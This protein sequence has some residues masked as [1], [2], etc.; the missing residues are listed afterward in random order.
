MSIFAPI[1]GYLTEVSTFEG[2]Y[3]YARE[4][5]GVILSENNIIELSIREENF[6]GIRLGLPV[7]VHLLGLRG[8]PL[9]GEV[10]AV[11]YASSSASKRRTVNV[12]LSVNDKTKR[13]ITP[14]MTGEAS[15]TKNIREKTLLIPRRAVFGDLVYTVKQNRIKAQPIKI[16]FRGLHQV[17]VSSGLRKGDLVVVEDLAMLRNDDKAHIVRIIEF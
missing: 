12:E 3:V 10:S 14:G 15:I 5:L 13:M 17:E 7:T 16:G 8:R 1:D 11:S 2:D 9:L 4:R 6:R